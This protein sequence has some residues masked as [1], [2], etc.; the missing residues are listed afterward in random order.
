VQLDP[1]KPMLTPPGTKHLKLKR[2]IV[3]STFAFEFNLR[4]YTEAA[5]AAALLG[6]PTDRAARLCHAHALHALRR[7]HEVRRCR[8]TLSKSS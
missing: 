3:L 8:L 5:A 2:D 7:Y 4:R 6:C 1:I